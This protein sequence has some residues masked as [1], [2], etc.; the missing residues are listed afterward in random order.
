MIGSETGGV[1]TIDISEHL[2][3]AEVD[4]LLAVYDEPIP[5]KY[6]TQ[7]S[8]LVPASSDRADDTSDARFETIALRQV[9]YVASQGDRITFWCGM[10]TAT[11]RWYVRM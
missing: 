8:T 2:T 10:S 9:A 5:V 4:L 1:E 6:G 7:V 11:G 3:P